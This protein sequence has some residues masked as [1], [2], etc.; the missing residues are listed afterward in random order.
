VVAFLTFVAMADTMPVLIEVILTP[1][2]I[3]NQHIIAIHK[4]R[5]NISKAINYIFD[6]LLS[7]TGHLIF[8]RTK[9]SDGNCF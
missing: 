5:G 3:Y 2:I 1:S 8:M 4:T 6:Y 7:S 9:R